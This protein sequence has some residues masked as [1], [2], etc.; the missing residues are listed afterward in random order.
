[1]HTATCNKCKRNFHYK[2]SDMKVPGGKDKEYI[3]CPYCSESYG[4]EVT[5]GFINSYKIEEIKS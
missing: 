1:M 4:S 2:V 3:Y 5:S